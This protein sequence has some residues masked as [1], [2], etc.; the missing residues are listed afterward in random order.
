MRT[1]RAPPFPPFLRCFDALF[2][3][4]RPFIFLC[5]EKRVTWTNFLREYCHKVR[6]YFLLHGIVDPSN[7]VQ[8]SLP[9][10]GTIFHGIVRAYSVIN[11]MRGYV[12][13]STYVCGVQSSVWRLPKYWPPTPSP[14]SECVLPPHRRRGVTHSPGAE[15]V[16]VNILEDVRHWIGLLQFNPSTLH[17]YSPLKIGSTKMTC[18]GS[19]VL[20]SWKIL[21]ISFQTVYSKIR[22]EGVNKRVNVE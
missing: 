15:G 20:K 10:S 2:P 7:L 17:S 11:M 22:K 3:S 19:C 16:G 5:F 14:P 13:Q 18:S 6:R 12:A 8:G 4:Y 9:R 21:A 1:A